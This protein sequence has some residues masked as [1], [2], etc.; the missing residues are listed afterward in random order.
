MNQKNTISAIII[1][2]NE[3]PRLSRCLSSL[4]WTDEQIVID[5]DSVDDTGLI[6]KKQGAIIVKKSG[7][8][9]AEL[10]NE[11]AMKAVGTWLLYVDA[12]EI[13]PDTLKEEILHLVHASI[14]KDAYFISRQN[15]YLGKRWPTRDKM[16]R[17]IKKQALI[18]WNG[19]LHEHP[20]IRGEVSE[21]IHPLLH[22]THR[23]ITEM[24]TKT[25]EWSDMEAK[26]RFDAYHPPMVW[27]RFL[28]VMF[29]AFFQSFV[30]Q[31]GWRAGTVGWIESI[32]QAFSM[33]I[34]YAKLWELQQKKR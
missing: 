32:Y 6:A 8:N 11:G 30:N 33:F 10:R 23:T 2:K 21:F 3:A 5:N 34:T 9:F 16:I 4:A 26:L 17:F 1:A 24:V 20:E 28:R 14:S 12:D 29:T 22:D 7:N 27:W 13:I 25:N 31:G 15:F 19:S 18:T